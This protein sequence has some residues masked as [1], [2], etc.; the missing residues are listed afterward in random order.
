MAITF[1]QE[2]KKQRYLILI[3]A[4]AILGVLGIVW[5]G[6]LSVPDEEALPPAFTFQKV[7]INFGILDR[8]DLTGLSH[9]EGVPVFEEQTGREN[10]FLPY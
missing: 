5:W 6:F 9:F 2:R 4:L 3:L 1:T 8:D 10:P 7:E